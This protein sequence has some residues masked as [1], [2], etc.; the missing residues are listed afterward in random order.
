[1]NAA[2]ENGEDR[3][4]EYKDENASC[5]C[6]DGAWCYGG[7]SMQAQH[8]TAPMQQRAEHEVGQG[9][10]KDSKMSVDLAADPAVEVKDTAVSVEDISE[11]K[12][13]DPAV[14][15]TTASWKAAN[16]G[17]IATGKRPARSRQ[18]ALALISARAAR[19]NGGGIGLRP[20]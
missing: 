1:M 15:I 11:H 14:V 6:I 8:A 18:K 5:D 4:P 2:N 16:G 10:V 13:Q 19:R 3:K 7:R 12:G 9:C 17:E 20:G